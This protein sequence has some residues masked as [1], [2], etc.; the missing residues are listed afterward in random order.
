MK[1]YG[2]QHV[3]GKDA[4]YVL[5]FVM[6]QGKPSTAIVAVVVWSFYVHMQPEQT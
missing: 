2:W 6:E 4:Q 5:Y 1:E 3:E